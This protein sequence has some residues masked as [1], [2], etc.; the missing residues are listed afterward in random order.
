MKA[1]VAIG[2]TVTV[3]LLAA[4]GL[5]AYGFIFS[6]ASDDA[7]TLVPEDAIGYFNLFLEPSNGQKQALED[8]IAKT[9]FESPEEAI[10]R[11]TDLTNEGLKEQGCTFEEDIEPWLGNQIAGFL[12]E[13]GDEGSGALLVGTD[14]GDAA[15]ESIRKCGEEDF[16][17][18]EERTYEGVDY[19]FYDDGAVGIVE[20]YLVIA[21]E[22]GFEDVV[23]TSAGGESLEGS[24]KFQR[25]LDPLTSDRL[26]VFYLDL[27]GLIEQ[28][29]ETGQADSEE[30]AAFEAIYGGGLDQPLSAG[31]FARSDA[32]VF[33]YASG[34]P[35]GEGAEGLTGAF[36]AAAAPELLGQLPGGSWG[37]LAVGSFGDY[38]NGILDLVGQSIP[39]G[40]ASLD[41]QFERMTGLSLSNDVLAWMGDLGL[42]VQGN[43]TSTLSGGLVLETTDEAASLA[44]VE[45]LEKFARKDDAPVKELTVAGAEGFTIQDPL[46]PQPINVAV[47]NGRVVVA[48][49]DLATEQAL[50]GQ[51]T[52]EQE[53]DVFTEAM[54][55]L[56]EEF[57]M[58]AFFEADAIQ[59][60]VE[61]EVLAT[62]TTYDPATGEIIANTE[63]QDRYEQDVKPFVDPLSYLAFGSRVE[64]DTATARLVIGVE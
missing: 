32:V 23:D 38:V 18:A 6:P 12:T 26:A 33:E 27:Q 46:Q 40:R 53:S 8:L 7:V 41:A 63:A 43:S 54:D 35:T 20:D 13:L 25:A 51:V 37:A 45:A 1:K 58:S 4:V 36:A 14:D 28:M 21:T 11:F 60:L 29:R 10:K 17:D 59:T 44:A 24:D 19:F 61:D 52:L 9:P 42:F 5:L 16:A 50:E 34:L 64:E 62:L 48:Y 55:G 56:G 22:A 57:N 47:G 2:I 31:L 3:L 15:I 49:G 39:G 30:I